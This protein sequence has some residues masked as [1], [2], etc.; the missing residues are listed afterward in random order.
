ML[1]VNDTNA[2]AAETFALMFK[3]ADAGR[4]IGTRTA[5][6]G[7]GPYGRV[8]R[9]L[10]GGRIVIPNRAA[11]SPDGDW[12]IENQGIEPDSVVPWPPTA[13]REGQDPQLEAAIISALIDLDQNPP[14]EPVKPEYPEHR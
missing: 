3:R 4:I 12:A 7:I 10:D 8:P 1:L 5:G 11:Y 13:W 9:L 2:S 6:A 14:P